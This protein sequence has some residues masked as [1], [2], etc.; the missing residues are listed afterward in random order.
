MSVRQKERELVG[1]GE[2]S[3]SGS[4]TKPKKRT[5]PST[6][7]D[8]GLAL[9]QSPPP[10][11]VAKKQ[12]REVV[13]KD[14][15][16]STAMM[17][18]GAIHSAAVLG[19][20]SAQQLGEVL[21]NALRCPVTNSMPFDVEDG[22]TE[23][24]VGYLTAL[25]AHLAILVNIGIEI[26][27]MLPSSISPWRFCMVAA[28]PDIQWH[29]M[30][31][32]TAV[33]YLLPCLPDFEYFSQRY[34]AEVTDM[35][36]SEVLSTITQKMKNMWMKCEEFRKSFHSFPRKVSYYVIWTLIVYR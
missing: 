33:G 15:G 4:S 9:F 12:K 27:W 26:E 7:A 35:L 24:Q 13:A 25:N 28:S 5:S 17:R 6:V 14:A 21:H 11:S 34:I 36:D 8:V 16:T 1:T 20:V 23:Y 29:E 3:I 32:T 31:N 2:P 10:S 30:D 18:V 22:L 19:G